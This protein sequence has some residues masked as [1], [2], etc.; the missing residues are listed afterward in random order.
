VLEILP[1]DIRCSFELRDPSWLHQDVFDALARHD[2]ALCLHDL[3]A[4]HPLVLTTD[5]TYVRYHGPDALNHPYDGRYG[6]ERMARD[7]ER[8]AAWLS[9][10]IDVHA[11]FNN[12]WYG[13]AVTDGADLRAKLAEWAPRMSSV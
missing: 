3:I 9:D 12:D 13:H 2:V 6:P 1:D 4:E 10:G 8:Y 5:W 11:Y 7:A